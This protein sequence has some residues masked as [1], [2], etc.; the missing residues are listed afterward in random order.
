M[1]E[2]FSRLFQVNIYSYCHFSTYYT[3]IKNKIKFSL[4]IRKFRGIGC[5][6]IYD[7]RPPVI[8]GENICAFP[9]I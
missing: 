9:H 1:I 5:K 7:K 6:V 8:D 2:G 4:Y 3:L